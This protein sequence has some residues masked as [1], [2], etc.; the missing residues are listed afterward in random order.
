MGYMT[1]PG[2][3]RS[4]AGM[5]L[6]RDEYV[7]VLAD[8]DGQVVRVVRTTIPHPSPQVME[9]SYLQGALALD[10]YG[11]KGRGLLVDARNAIGR[12]EPEYEAPLRRARE[13]NDAGFL[14]IAVLLRTSAGMLQLMRLS[15]ED[16]TVRLITT[17]EQDA[18]RYL[19]TGSV[20][21]ST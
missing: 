4:S 18:I 7:T 19:L 3:S 2:S 14:R 9:H 10:R 12:N 5:E 15:D 11:R 8:P 6:Y 16:G 17:N 13:R 20:G 1:P 21:R